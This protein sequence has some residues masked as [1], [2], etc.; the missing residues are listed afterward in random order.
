MDDLDQRLIAELRINARATIPTLAGILGVARG[1]VQARLDKLVAAGVI[2]GFTVKL[3][4]N[5]PDAMVRGANSP[6]A[7]SSR[8]SRHSGAIRDS[9]RFT[10]QTASGT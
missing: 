6:A 7:T 8:R 5:R 2:A 9:P 4:D 10:P 3:R 1:T